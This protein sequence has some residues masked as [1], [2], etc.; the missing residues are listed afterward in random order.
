M[1][2]M[3]EDVDYDGLAWRRRIHSSASWLC[4]GLFHAL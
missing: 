1:Q 2:Q 4:E 3:V